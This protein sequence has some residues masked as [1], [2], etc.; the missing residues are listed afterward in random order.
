M[1][2]NIIDNLQKTVIK[3]AKSKSI[4]LYNMVP[5]GTKFPY[6]QI[7]NYKFNGHLDHKNSKALIEFEINIFDQKNSPQTVMF[8]ADEI[9]KIL[10]RKNFEEVKIIKT[11]IFTGEIAQKTDGVTQHLILHYGIWVEC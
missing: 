11:K 9:N 2:F 1:N 3:L 4:N 8:I 5:S 10:A 6:A 7:G